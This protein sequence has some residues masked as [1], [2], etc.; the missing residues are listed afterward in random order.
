MRKCTI[1]TGIGFQWV[2]M[3]IFGCI[4]EA[5]GSTTPMFTEENIFLWQIM[6]E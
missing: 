3:T 4:R 6:E 2:S 1:N 5:I